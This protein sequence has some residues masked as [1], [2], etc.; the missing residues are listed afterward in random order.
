MFDRL[1]PM[2]ADGTISAPVAATFGFDQAKE[3]ITQAA[4]SSGKVC[5][6]QTPDC[7]AGRLVWMTSEAG[8]VGFTRRKRN[9]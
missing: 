4:Q 8:G 2:V 1:A 7:A 5:S 3:A 9:S 6:G